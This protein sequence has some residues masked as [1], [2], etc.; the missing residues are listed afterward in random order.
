METL[1]SF[2]YDKPQI[3]PALVE[4]A[5]PNKSQSMP[6]AKG[7]ELKC[8]TWSELPEDHLSG[9]PDVVET[10]EKWKYEAVSVSV[11]EWVIRRKM[12]LDIQRIETCREDRGQG[13]R[14][15]A[16][17][18]L[19]CPSEMVWIFIEGRGGR[20]VRNHLPGR[21]ALS[22]SLVP[23]THSSGPHQRAF[24]Y[25]CFPLSGKHFPPPASHFNFHSSV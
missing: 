13:T 24:Y 10:S 21:H 18:S 2:L 14:D 7:N 19:S 5:G 6:D 25:R 3:R 11:L 4:N 23:G 15:F 1:D 20:C 9:K 8:E 22:S 12:A 17:G 16:W